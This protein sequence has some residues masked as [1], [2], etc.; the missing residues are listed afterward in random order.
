MGKVVELKGSDIIDAYD[1]KKLS[2]DFGYSCANFHVDYYNM[3]Y[4]HNF[5]VSKNMNG[6]DVDMFDIF[7]D[8]TD[9]ISCFVYINDSGKIEGR[10]MFFKGKQLLDHKVF[11]INTKMGKEIFYLYGYYG[12]YDRLFDDEIIKKVLDTYNGL[13]ILDK[14]YLLNGVKHNKQEYWIMEINKMDYKKYPPIDF[15]Y[16][17]TELK[18]FSNFNPSTPIKNWLE[19]TYNVKDVDFNIAYRYNPNINRD[20]YSFHWNQKYYD[21]YDE[22]NNSDINDEIEDDEIEDDFF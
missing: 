22:F 13:I 18:S 21:D 20:I 14:G 15:L 5:S 12:S 11:P 16:L 19:D 1:G 2:K 17:S 8:N 4:S 10:R 9:N 3:K 7:V 6:N